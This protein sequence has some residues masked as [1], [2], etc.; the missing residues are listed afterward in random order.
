MHACLIMSTLVRFY[1][2]SYAIEYLIN[3]Y[4]IMGNQSSFL[5]KKKSAKLNK[6]CTS[7]PPGEESYIIR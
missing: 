2:S 7:F 5:I 4:A 1:I 6:I 3:I